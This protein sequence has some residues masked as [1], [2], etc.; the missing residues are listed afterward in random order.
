MDE[1][2]VVVCTY[3]IPKGGESLLYSLDLNAVGEGVA[4]MLEFLVCC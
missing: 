1:S 2:Y 3:Y 4:E